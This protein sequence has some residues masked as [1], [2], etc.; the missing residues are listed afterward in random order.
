MRMASR[1]IWNRQIVSR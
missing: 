1:S